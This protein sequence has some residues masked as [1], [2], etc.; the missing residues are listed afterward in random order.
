V[1]TE[2]EEGRKEKKRHIDLE[3]GA[4]TNAKLGDKRRGAGPTSF[5]LEGSESK[6]LSS[7]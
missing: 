3:L 7:C 2:V 5:V 6:L 4:A 1:Q